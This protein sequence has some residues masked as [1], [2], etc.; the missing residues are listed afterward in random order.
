M[1]DLER[2]ANLIFPDINETIEDLEKR[3]PERN[4]KEGAIVDR[5]A[6]SPTG[7]LHSGSLFT[8]MIQWHLAKKSGGV[9]MLRLEDTDTKRE[10]TGSGEQ[11]LN[12]LKKFGIVPTE[13]YFGTYEEGAYA[14]YIQS[15]RASIYNTVIKEMIRRGDAYPAFESPLELDELRKVQEKNKENPGYYGKYAKSSFLS[16]AEAIEKIENGE[17]YIIRFRSKGSNA[18]KLHF[19]D[20]IKGDVEVTENEQHI[21]I[22]K[23]DGLPTYHFAHLCDDHFMRTTHVLRGEEWLSSLPIHIELFTRLGFKLPEY[24]HLPVIMK[25]D[26][27]KRRKLSKRLDKEAAVSFFLESGYPKMAI[28][29][30]LFTLANSNFEEWRLENMDASIFDFTF[31]F[32]K[33]NKDG[34]LF[35]LDKIND[36]SKERLSRLTKKEFTDLALEYAKEYDKQLLDLIERD[37]D[38]FESIVNIEREKENPRK[39]YTKFSDVF[40]FIK[41]FY[42]D[43]YD[44]EIK[45]ELPFNPLRTKEQI[46]NVLCA[47]LN[48]LGLDKEEQDWFNNMKETMN[49]LGFASNKKEL[50]ENPDKFIA[51]IG[52]AS[53]IIRIALT[54]RKSSPN[55]YY[56]EKILGKEEIERRFNKIIEL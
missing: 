25:L 23:S 49:P 54:G 56:V 1:T 2:L 11:L 30:Y 35:D 4:L 47:H 15:K 53:E 18:N 46:K 42:N 39:D 13:G 40:D 50:R 52:D 22:L 33:F 5:F 3:Y 37:R 7:F 17:K 9:F 26:N 51:T 36:I 38:Y 19:H 14:P 55:L 29:E 21:V 44:E 31:T 16:P 10:V 6:P 43:Y 34:A 32:E 28:L 24:G 41:F 48:N 12:E 45:G 20:L 27:G 8:A